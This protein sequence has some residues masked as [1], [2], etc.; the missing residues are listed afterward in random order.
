MNILEN[1]PVIRDE[2]LFSYSQYCTDLFNS[3]HRMQSMRIALLVKY[4]RCYT[5][6]PWVKNEIDS[7]VCLLSWIYMWVR[8]HTYKYLLQKIMAGILSQANELLMFSV[9]YKL[10]ENKLQ[11]KCMNWLQQFINTF[12]SFN[13]LLTWRKRMLSTIISNRQSMYKYDLPI[14]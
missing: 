7:Q 1:V 2:K 12:C 9:N 11:L 3:L 4:R 5:D 6:S 10:S 13:R 14:S 8:T